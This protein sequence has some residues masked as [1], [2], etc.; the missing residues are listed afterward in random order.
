MKTFFYKKKHPFWGAFLLIFSITHRVFT[1]PVPGITN[2]VVQILLCSPAQQLLALGR[3]SIAGGDI[4]G[5]AAHDLIR[6]IQTVGTI[7]CLDHIQYRAAL[8]GAKVEKVV[9]YAN[10][11]E[12]IP[13]SNVLRYYLDNGSWFAIRPSGTEPKIKFYFYTKQGSEE[14]A[15]EVNKEIKE[16][17]FAYVNAVE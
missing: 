5:T 10:G 6:Q 11:Y 16:E 2:H 13:A 4:T 7:E 12:D 3:I 8:A 1:L 9:D 15:R 17:V 14:E